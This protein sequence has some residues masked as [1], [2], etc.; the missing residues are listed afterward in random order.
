MD[1]F[2]TLQTSRKLV[3]EQGF[4]KIFGVLLVINVVNSVLSALPVIGLLGLFLIPFV[5]MIYVTMYENAIG[6]DSEDEVP[7]LEAELIP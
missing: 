1:I 5:M 7:A 3:H 4:W 2:E 6:G